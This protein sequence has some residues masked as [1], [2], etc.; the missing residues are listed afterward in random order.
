MRD[1]RIFANFAFWNR[2]AVPDTKIHESTKIEMKIFS[3]EE[4]A[5][6]E[7]QTLATEDI[8]TL[9][10]I[11]N[12]GEAV[13]AEI[14][15]RWMP[16]KRLLVFAGW[17]N[18][19]ADALCAAR[20][21]A[22]QG[23]RPEVY[24]FNIRGNRLTPE[25]RICR[26]RLLESCAGAVA[27]KEITGQEP[28]Q[29]PE[30]DA[31]SLVIDGLF[32]SGLTGVLPRSFQVII[33]QLNQSGAAIVAIDMPSGLLS[34]WN[35][36]N[37][38][39]NMIHA[40]LT[41]ALTA[42][43]MSFMLSDNANVVGEWKVLDIGVSHKAISQA[44]YTF[45]LVRKSTVTRYLPRR[46]TFSSKADYGNAVIAAGSY[47]M[48]GAACLAAMG[49]LRSGAGKVT[50]K[51]A[52][53]GMPVIQSTVP[54]AMFKGD[55]GSDCITSLA[56]VADC[57]A[58]GVGP[59]IGTE[60]PTIDAL[61]AMLKSRNAS[62]KTVVLD[63]DALN[64]I[65]QRPLLLNYLPVLSVLTPHA[66]EFDRI[67]GE[68]NGDEARLKRALEVSKFHKVIIVLKG[69]FTAIV[70]PDGKVFFNSSGCPAMATPGSGDVLTGI[71]TS[72]IAQGYKPE[73]AVFIAA[74]VHG[75]AG[76]L[77]GAQNGEYGTTAMDIANC[78]GVAIRNL[79]NE[80]KL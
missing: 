69:R 20:N 64:C 3:N 76:E 80:S 61:E 34:D 66:G 18:N 79:S 28:F 35:N 73:K 68:H 53:T 51:S 74:Y 11:E 42:P 67:F 44:P 21:L 50:V 6:L 62:S 56:D 47:G 65:A 32:G 12:S 48:Y 45:Y 57:E 55:S 10:L 9:D 4:I 77:A 29:W 46:K 60:T 72:F 39:E 49:A 23:Y 19:G 5:R 43:R 33:Q 78:V 71:I 40:T 25:C 15:A 31:D 2:Y 24:L 41:L 70:R 7:K 8:T 26:D 16:G 30:P 58:L 36:D 37:S 22:Q 59:G 13:A 14:S 27:F 1:W 54:C 52:G 17:G 63:A 38:R 75:V